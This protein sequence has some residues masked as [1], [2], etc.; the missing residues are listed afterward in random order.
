[1]LIDHLGI[2]LY[3]NQMIDNNTYVLMRSIGRIAFPIFAFLIVEGYRKT[4]DIRKYQ[5]RLFI[6]A[7]VGQITY[8]M[9]C[10]KFYKTIGLNV[11]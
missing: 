4:K 2:V 11:L 9:F 5:L 7:L 1:M 10:M 8:G 6:S 3:C